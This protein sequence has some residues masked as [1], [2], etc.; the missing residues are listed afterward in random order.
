[1]PRGD[2]R[3]RAPGGKMNLIGP[4]VAERRETLSMTQ[5]VL[6]AKTAHVTAGAWAP[7]WQDI[8]RIE[9]G[10]RIVADTEVVALAGALLCSPCWLL[11]G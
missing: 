9:N 7:A 11:T 3:L 8:S 5:D 2:A 10:S 1:M 6:C 4:R